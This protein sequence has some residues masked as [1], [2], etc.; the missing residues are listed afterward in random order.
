MSY[1][2]SLIVNSDNEQHID[3]LRIKLTKVL[4]KYSEMD[5]VIT[6]SKVFILNG[7]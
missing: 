5:R 2:L 6:T 4:E 3:N 7:D 1:I